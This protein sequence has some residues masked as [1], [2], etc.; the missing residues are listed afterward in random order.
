M[1]YTKYFSG[2]NIS[3]LKTS[4]NNLSSKVDSLKTKNES[5]FNKVGSANWE[6]DAKNQFEQGFDVNAAIL[7]SIKTQITNFVSALALAD[8]VVEIQDYMKTDGLTYSTLK[9]NVSDL[10]ERLNSFKKEILKV[11]SNAS[12][13]TSSLSG[14][15]SK[16]FLINLDGINSVKDE[17]S[18]LSSDLVSA[19]DLFLSMES[20]VSSDSYLKYAW[21]NIAKNFDD[22]MKKRD[23]MYSWINNYVDN[24]KTIENNLPDVVKGVT[25]S[26]YATY[27]K[28]RNYE[29]EPSFD[30]YKASNKGEEIVEPVSE[31]SS[32]YSGTG[33]SGG[34]SY[35][36][37]SGGSYSGTNTD[38]DGSGT[39][40]HP[41]DLHGDKEYNEALYNRELKKLKKEYTNDEINYDTYVKRYD[42]LYK[43]YY[44]E[45]AARNNIRDRLSGL[46]KVA[47]NRKRGLS[48]VGLTEQQAAIKSWN[49]LNGKSSVF[50]TTATNIHG[51]YGYNQYLKNRYG[52]K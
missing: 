38:D 12:Y 9:M 46:N 52:K 17:Y 23:N 41:N 44:G 16:V 29:S 39:I 36:S 1:Y 25:M 37:P 28:T 31:D 21:S 42:I 48:G 19:Y 34:G 14:S 24:L 20:M 49:N 35:Y 33:Y 26:T 32:S 18:S 8:K 2:I 22:L 3:T 15:V 43:N 51:D 50:K 10:E 6:C 40:G 7:D 5:T 30:D 4:L 47:S 27:A 45:I 13:L 11:S